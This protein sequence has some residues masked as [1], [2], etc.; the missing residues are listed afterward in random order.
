[1]Q[2]FIDKLTEYIQI[3]VKYGDLWSQYQS[4]LK[5]RQESGR[6]KPKYPLRIMDE[7]EWYLNCVHLLEKL[8]F[9]QLLESFENLQIKKEGGLKQYADTAK[10]KIRLAILKSALEQLKL[11]HLQSLKS[12]ISAEHLGS[13][14]DQG[15]ELFEKKHTNVAAILCRIVIEFKLRDLCQS[16]NITTSIKDKTPSK[17]RSASD[18]NIDLKKNNVYPQHMERKIQ[19]YLDIGNDAAHGNF[20]NYKDEDI[21]GMIN[22]IEDVLLNIT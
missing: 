19:S 12:I 7:T 16:H 8:E 13:L 15:R 9:N 22:F 18:L 11:S 1:M 4:K 14:F 2:I 6:G 10:Y 3:G 17:H 5:K 21:K 20:Q